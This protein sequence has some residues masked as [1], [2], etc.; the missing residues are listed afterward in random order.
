MTALFLRHQLRYPQFASRSRYRSLYYH[1][2]LL[3]QE[4][5]PILQIRLLYSYFYEM[6]KNLLRHQ[7][8]PLFVRSVVISIL[9]I[10]YH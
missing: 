5:Q 4:I 9:Q 8:T 2:L 3:N 7:G 10:Q 6:I 1:R